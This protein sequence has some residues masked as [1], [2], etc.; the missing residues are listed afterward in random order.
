VRRFLT[1]ALASVG[2]LIVFAILDVDSRASAAYLST[3]SRSVGATAGTSAATDET[4]GNPSPA[5]YKRSELPLLANQLA[6]TGTTNS[7]NG[8]SGPSSPAATLPPK[9]PPPG[10]LVVYF[11]EPAVR[12]EL[13]KHID[14]IL[15]PPR[16]V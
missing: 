10:N 6:G 16:Q 9:E 14:S 15:D 1:L 4:P 3:V 11:R 7:N 8:P 2:V 5:N 13:T 12:L